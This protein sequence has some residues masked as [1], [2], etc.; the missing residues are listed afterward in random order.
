MNS[1]Q[2]SYP[3]YNSKINCSTK[4]MLQPVAVVLTDL[5]IVWFFWFF[6]KSLFNKKKEKKLKVFPL[7]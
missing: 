6:S 3:I 1:K 7:L 4:N 5:F 2:V